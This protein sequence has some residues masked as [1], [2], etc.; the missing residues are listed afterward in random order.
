MIWISFP[1]TLQVKLHLKT[2]TK[3]RWSPADNLLNADPLNKLI[4]SV[5]TYWPSTGNAIIVTDAQMTTYMN[6]LGAINAPIVIG[7]IAHDEVQ[8]NGN[9]PH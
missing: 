6:A 5:H 2:H 4:F 3:A 1:Y 8:A 7:E 9:L